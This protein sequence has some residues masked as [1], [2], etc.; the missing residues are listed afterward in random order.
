MSPGSH[1]KC[2]AWHCKQ[3]EACRR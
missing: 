1:L 3:K 2:I